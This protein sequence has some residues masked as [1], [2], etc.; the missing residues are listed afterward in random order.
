MIVIALVI[1]PL[2]VLA[3]VAVACT[4]AAVATDGYRRVPRR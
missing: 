2:G 4:L 3:L 1:A